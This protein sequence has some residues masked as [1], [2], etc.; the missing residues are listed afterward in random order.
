MSQNL[1]NLLHKIRRS[2][3]SRLPFADQLR[4]WIYK[5]PPQPVA[6]ALREL[7]R[8]PKLTI[9]QLGAYVGASDND[10]LFNF[11][12]RKAHHG[13]K[14]VLVEPSKPSFQLLQ[15]NYAG[16]PGVSLENIAVADFSGTAEFY[17]LDVDPTEHGFPEWLSQLSS[18]KEERM[19]EIWLRYEADP[20]IQAFYLRHRVKEQVDC[21]TF[22]DLMAAHQLNR[23]DLLQMDVEGFEWEILQT[24]DFAS[25]SIRFINYESV[26]LLDQKPACEARLKQQGYWLTDCGKDTLACRADDLH[27]FDGTG[28]TFR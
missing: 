8:L 9:V 22:A 28:F 24:I 16:V 5:P 4:K 23:I 26:L 14:A 27:L 13:L 2:I 12:R 7:S 6:I 20:E 25:Q 21:L 15:Q 18:L 1:P 19:G 10:P 11:I 17:R 3:V